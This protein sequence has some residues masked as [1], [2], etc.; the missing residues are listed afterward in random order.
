MSKKYYISFTGEAIF[1]PKYKDYLGGRAEI[2]VDD[3]PYNI[4]EIRFLTDKVKEFNEFREEWECKEVDDLT[5]FRK[6]MLRYN[7]HI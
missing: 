4:E 2:Y 5:E 7:I 6:L 3:E 1:N